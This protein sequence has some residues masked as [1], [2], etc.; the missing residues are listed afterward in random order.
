M[1]PPVIELTRSEINKNL[2]KGHTWEALDAQRRRFLAATIMLQ[3][4][5]SNSL[6]FAAMLQGSIPLFNTFTILE[7]EGRPVFGR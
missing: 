6:R 3:R 7:D 1:T 5:D 4:G 2:P